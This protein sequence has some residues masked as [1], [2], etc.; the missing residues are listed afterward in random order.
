MLLRLLRWT[1]GLL[2]GLLVLGAIPIVYVETQCTA[3]PNG[4]QAAAPYRSVLP[5][6]TGKRPEARTWLTYPEWYIVYSAE[7]YGRYLA[8]GKPPSGFS[9]LRQI[10]GFWSGL[11]AVNRAA[12]SAEA[13]DAKVMLYTIGLSFT[14]EMAIKGA[15]ENVFGRIS[16]WIGG[17]K[18]ANDRYSAEIWQRY[19]AFMHETPWYQF[20]FL[21]ALK[22][23]WR[24]E[25]AS[26]PYRNWERR[27]A[28]STEF[29][30]KS[31]YGGAIGF[32]SNNA[33][34]PAQLSVPLVLGGTP[35]AIAAADPRLKLN[36]LLPGGLAAVEAPRYAQLTD[37]LVKLSA[38]PVELF[39]I[40]GNDDVLLT[41]IAPDAAA[42]PQGSHGLF[43]EPL[44]DR[45][46][47]R[48]LG[49][50]VKVPRL[51]AT[52]REARAAGIEIE[53]VYDY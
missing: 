8:A 14:A 46:G 36:G 10:G 41:V 51:L 47:W 15:Y 33:L 30:I 31:A 23:L 32:A 13:G 49:L 24:T 40:A 42:V 16:E 53:H 28:L 20:G 4:W 27:L 37:A 7:S 50:A 34:G 38:T 17:W 12:G 39:E 25:S 3:P 43:A 21:D 1:G 18:S 48:R 22:G 26:A 45:P 52:I 2:F 35:Q 5:S 6:D 44:D 11:C 19:G 29:G 9:Y